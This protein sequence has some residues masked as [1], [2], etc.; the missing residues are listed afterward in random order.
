MLV[1]KWISVNEAMPPDGYKVLITDSKEMT[2]G[3]YEDGQWDNVEGMG[4]APYFWM[5][6]PSL[7]AI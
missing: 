7:V 3:W 4:M 5:P 1:C 2:I 6:M